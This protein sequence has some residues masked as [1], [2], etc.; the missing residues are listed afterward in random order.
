[1]DIKE[2]DMRCENRPIKS[3]LLTI[4]YVSAAAA[5]VFLSPS[6]S[7]AQTS[8]RDTRIDL[9]ARQRALWD[10]ERMKGKLS[11]RPKEPGLAYEQI[12]VDFEQLQIANYNLSV[13]TGPVLDYEKIRKETAEVK[14][15]A[16]RLKTNLLLPEP[17]KPEKDEKPKDSDQA[18]TAVELKTAINDLDTLVKSFVF[19]PIFQQPGVV[20]VANSVKARRDLERV[21]RLSKNIHKSAE[22]LSKTA[23]QN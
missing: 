21:I 9:Q 6:T 22:A 17:E 19:N 4:L 13:E 15:R 11:R 3:A 12:R 7:G 5:F 20:D 16:A 18:F 8:G 2:T 14:K 10:L 1:L 23:T